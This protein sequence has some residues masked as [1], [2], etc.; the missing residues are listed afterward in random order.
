MWGFEGHWRTHDA[1][2][3]E[4]P[5]YDNK[6]VIISAD[7]QILATAH[8]ANVVRIWS[9][10]SGHLVRKISATS[11]IG[12]LVCFSGDNSS[13]ITDR[14][15]LAVDGIADAISS[16]MEAIEDSSTPDT[17]PFTPHSEPLSASA[18]YVEQ[19]W[20]FR[21]SK[22]L[23]WLPPNYRARSHAVQHG[24]VAL[25]HDSG[26]VTIIHFDLE[27]EDR[28]DIDAKGRRKWADSEDADLESIETS[29]SVSDVESEDEKSIDVTL[30][31][32]TLTV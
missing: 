11:D 27:A 31:P 24:I 28:I 8:S 4:S 18:L 17:A 3:G 29:S 15:T 5:G 13:L 20:I 21:G 30:G 23:L 22:P 2:D 19:P 1:P 12:P 14:G 32:S 6:S 10:D 16:N 7:S 26:D 25:G 9:V